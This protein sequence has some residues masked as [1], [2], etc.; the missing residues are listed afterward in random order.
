M[1]VLLGVVTLI[2]L[3]ITVA[4][5]AAAMG[6]ENAET[7]QSAFEEKP[8]NRVSFYREKIQTHTNEELEQFDIGGCPPVPL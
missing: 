6:K 3:G 8:D 1:T 4:A 5:V 2:I 7:P